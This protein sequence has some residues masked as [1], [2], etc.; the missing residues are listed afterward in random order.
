MYIQYSMILI[1]AHL[2]SSIRTATPGAGLLL[3]SVHDGAFIVKQLVNAP[4]NEASALKTFYSDPELTIIGWFMQTADDK[5]MIRPKNLHEH[6]RE[7]DLR[8]GV[9]RACN[10]FHGFCLIEESASECEVRVVERSGVAAFLQTCYDL[11]PFIDDT[12]HALQSCDHESTDAALIDE[13][14]MES[15]RRSCL[16]YEGLVTLYRLLMLPDDMLIKRLQLLSK[17][18]E[19][20][21]R[22]ESCFKDAS[23]SPEQLM[24]CLASVNISPV[25]K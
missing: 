19:R 15:Y 1:P 12:R 21:R 24:Q 10:E 4:W 5:T 20:K 8:M 2:T 23:L 7:T 13:H 22:L 14:H 16:E 25:S 9:V 17:V 6:F 18:E 11:E 3:G